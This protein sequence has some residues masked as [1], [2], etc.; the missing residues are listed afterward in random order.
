MLSTSGLQCRWLSSLLTLEQCSSS[1]TAEKP[2]QRDDTEP[3]KILKSCGGLK[4]VLSQT[5]IPLNKYFS[6]Y[7]LYVRTYRLISVQKTPGPSHQGKAP[8]LPLTQISQS[9]EWVTKALPKPGGERQG[10]VAHHSHPPVPQSSWKLSNCEESKLWGH[11]RHQ[12]DPQWQRQ[13]LYLLQKDL[14]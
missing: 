8:F 6:V 3:Q 2:S 7:F 1:L 14:N 10:P 13:P 4:S 12:E 5:K 11:K 9:T